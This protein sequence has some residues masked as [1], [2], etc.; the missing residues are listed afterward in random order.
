MRLP[1]LVLPA[2]LAL[3]STG[4]IK[5]MILDGTIEGTRTASA[6]FDTIG[7]YELA[8]TAAQAG[9][10]QFEGFH[11]LGPD[12]EDA[13][14]LLTKGWAGYAYGFAEDELEMAEDQNDDDLA[15][16]H[17]LRA[18]MAYDRAVFYGLELLRHKAEGFE[19][20]KKNNDT[21]QKWLT[22]NFTDKEDAEKMFWLGYAWMARVGVM[23]GGDPEVGGAL[24]AELFVGVDMMRHSVKLDESYEHYSGLI[25]LGAYGVRPMSPASEHE[26]AKKHFET[27]LAATQRKNLMVQFNYA[28]KYACAL[29]DKALY[30][31]LLN[32]VLAAEDPDPQQRL[33]NAIAKRRA[34]RWLAP[35]RMKEHC[36]F[37]SAPSPAPA[38]PPAAPPG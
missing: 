10:V 34:R 18:K 14:F 27:A 32:E 29:N 37:Q 19:A 8:R 3:C 5:K 16:Y 20:A 33:T 6:A 13:L 30:E 25:A 35:R 7:D 9:L 1:A 23:L 26:E 31:K 38:P 28:T 36:S 22:S 2:A 12:N 15:N 21:F 4:C 24:I 17:R 11:K